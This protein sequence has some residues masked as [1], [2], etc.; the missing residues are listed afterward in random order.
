MPELGD[1]SPGDELIVTVDPNAR[2]PRRIRVRVTKAAPVWIDVEAL[3]GTYLPENARRFRRDNQSAKAGAEHW[4]PHFHT[5]EQWAY[6][7][8][9]SRT[10]EYLR[11]V[12][13]QAMPGSRFNGDPVALANAVRRGL[14]EDEL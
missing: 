4:T 1:V 11:E 12:G 10:H 5:L 7:E 9:Q 6:R 13:V 3:D 2:R 14:G 8:R